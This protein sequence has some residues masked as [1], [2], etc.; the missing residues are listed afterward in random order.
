MGLFYSSRS[1][2]RSGSYVSPTQQLL[3]LS[4]KKCLMFLQE[5]LIS[6]NIS[7]V[8]VELVRKKVCLKP[9]LADEALR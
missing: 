1:L 6:A 7:N 5:C 8:C 3:Y 9:V 4:S 2:R